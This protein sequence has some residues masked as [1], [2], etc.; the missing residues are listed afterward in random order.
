MNLFGRLVRRDLALMAAR[1]GEWLMPLVFFL[2]VAMLLPFAIGP[3]PALLVRL[4]PGIL[5]LSLIHI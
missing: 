3:E 5:W 4:G 2:L 1:P